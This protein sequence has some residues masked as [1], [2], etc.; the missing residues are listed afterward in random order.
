MKLGVVAVAVIA[1]VG[2]SSKGY[3]ETD[4]QKIERL[5]RQLKLLS[6]HVFQGSPSG[7]APGNTPSEA[8]HVSSDL[9]SPAPALQPI[10]LEQQQQQLLSRFEELEH[11]LNLVKQ[12]VN[13]L[14][15]FLANKS[16]PKEPIDEADEAIGV[17]PQA[18]SEK[19]GASIQADKTADVAAR[20]KAQAESKTVLPEGSVQEQYDHAL[21]TLKAGQFKEASKQ[22]HTFLKNHGDHELAAN[23]TYWLGET[24]FAQQN[25]EK[26][27]VIFAQG[28]KAFSKGSKG[29]DMLLKIAMCLEQQ[30]NPK[31]AC[32]TI[33]QLYSNHPNMAEGIKQA[34]QKAKNRLK[35]G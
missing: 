2:F 32:V 8:P 9:D 20:D 4:T 14:A 15:D 35:C 1:L 10:P 16:N 18:K 21:A 28:Y 5:E 12:Q 26:A 34:A 17:N 11:E 30:K 25:Y 24:Y 6:Q 31:D 3:A 22:L 29:A 7:S 13:D 19:A 23:A 33:E 27:V